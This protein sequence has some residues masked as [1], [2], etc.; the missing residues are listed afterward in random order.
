MQVVRENQV[1]VVVGETGSGKTT[2]L[3]QVCLKL[4]FSV[5][6]SLCL[7]TFFKYDIILINSRSL[8]VHSIFMKMGT[9]PTALLVARNQG[10]W[11]P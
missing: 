4:Y 8:I 6:L 10:E 5:S 7:Y 1:I 2:Q 3:T 9:Q 11:Q